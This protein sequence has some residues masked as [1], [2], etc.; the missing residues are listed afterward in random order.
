VWSIQEVVDLPALFI[1]IVANSTPVVVAR[2]LGERYS[3]P[4]DA[5]RSLRDGRAL[6]GAHKTWRG[7]ISGIVAAGFAGIM[8][9]RGFAVGALFGAMAL[10]GDLCSSFLKRR[11]GFIS[12]QSIPLL[13][14]LPEALLPMLVLR[15]TMGLDTAAMVGTAIVFT[16]LDILTA[17]FRA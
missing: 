16:L 7:L 2:F 6:F 13:D 8:V 3:A 17:R 4:I 10:T 14:Q 5:N 9:S 11:L 15:G 12:G 1:L